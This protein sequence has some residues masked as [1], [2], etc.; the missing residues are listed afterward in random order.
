MSPGFRIAAAYQF[1]E[2]NG[3]AS[4]AELIRAM[5]IHP[6]I[7]RA[8]G[9]RKGALAQLFEE[10]GVMDEFVAR[11]WPSRH[12]PAGEK[13]RKTFR[14]RKELNER[15]LRGE[16]DG[17]YDGDGT[18]EPEELDERALFALEAH[19]R[20]FLA[21]NLGRVALGTNGLKLYRDSTG[22]SGVEYQTA[23]GRIDLLT[24]DGTGAFYVFELKLER[25]PDRA[26]G[27]LARYMGWVK[28]ELAAGKPVHGVLVASSIEPKLKYAASVLPNVSLLEYELSFKVR[29][30]EPMGAAGE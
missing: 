15:R 2:Q 22:K 8:S 26:L 7:A 21:G 9:V 24:V 19:L 3:L 30:V 6:S 16:D 13:R 11:H 29:G 12:T 5:A 27:Q 23:V 25:G 20:D 4:E 18:D 10:R 1:A 28:V 17:T 14:Q